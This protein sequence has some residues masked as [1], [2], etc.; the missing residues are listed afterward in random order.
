MFLGR[1]EGRQALGLNKRRQSAIASRLQTSTARPTHF[2]AYSIE[3]RTRSGFPNISKRSAARTSIGPRE[4]VTGLPKAG[5][6]DVLDQD[7]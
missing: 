3:A 7:T 5:P 2:A 1:P 6:D 4:P